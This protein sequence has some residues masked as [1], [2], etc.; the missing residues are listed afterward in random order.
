MAHVLQE[1]LQAVDTESEIFRLIKKV[2]FE[3][4]SH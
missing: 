4:I 1:G 3:T 2:K